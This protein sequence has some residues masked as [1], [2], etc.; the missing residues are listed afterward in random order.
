[1]VV[2][3]DL[4]WLRALPQLLQPWGLTVTTLADPQQFWTVLQLVQPDALVLDVKM[5]EINGLEL[6]QVLRSDIHWQRLP[7]LFLSANNN[8][9]AQQEAFSVGADDYLCKP[10]LG[11]E[12][13]QR[14]RHRLARLQAGPVAS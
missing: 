7:I 6:C 13:A 10:M 5:P 2:D 14:I 3:D 1:M 9:I 11:S 4:Q 12:L 8:P